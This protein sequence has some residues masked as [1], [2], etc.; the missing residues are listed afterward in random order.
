MKSKMIKL[1]LLLFLFLFIFTSYNP[2][3][4]TKTVKINFFPI[5]KILI[6]NNYI[7]EDKELLNEF[8]ALY[9]HNLVT[10]QPKSIKNLINKFDFISAVTIKKIYPSTIKITIKEKKPIAININK[11]KRFYITETG[12]LIKYRKI[13]DFENLPKVFGSSKY[14]NDLYVRLIEL[15]FQTNKIKSYY[16]FDSGRWDIELKDEKI[17]KLPIKD[18]DLSI[19]NYLKIK[20]EINYD[21]FK[22]FD[23][24]IKGQLI[25]N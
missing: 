16:Y 25:L 22:I 21:K 5:N 13:K 4:N 24:R 9:G 6:K 2:S 11:K 18:N 10:I 3:K 1:H 8:S 23:Y 12:S 14:F 7:I 20:K 15:N 17:I 19:L